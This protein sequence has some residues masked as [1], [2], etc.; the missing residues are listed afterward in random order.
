VRL[1]LD[2]HFVIWLA[3]SP[4]KIRAAEREQL[5]QPGPPPVV[6]SVTFWELRLKWNRSSPEV[7]RTLLE[8]VAA[9]QFAERHGFALAELTSLDCATS[10]ETP[11]THRDPFDEQLLIHAQRLGA[12]LLTR[13]RL[14]TD[15]PLAYRPG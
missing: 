8:P 3:R 11:L 6:S 1:L 12:K 5:A 4:E 9:I 14:L 7:R 2:T 15:H 13:D 10:L